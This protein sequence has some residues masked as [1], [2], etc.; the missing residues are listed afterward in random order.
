MLCD[1]LESGNRVG[2]GM[3]IQERGDIRLPMADSC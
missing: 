3:E 1:N 2:G